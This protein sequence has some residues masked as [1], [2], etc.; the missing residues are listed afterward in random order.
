MTTSYEHTDDPSRSALA[1]PV[2]V[3][4]RTA[5]W[6]VALMSTPTTEAPSY[7][8]A[9]SAA[10]SE[11]SVSARTHE[12]PPCSSPNGWVL[13]CTGIVPAARSGAASVIAI[14][15]RAPRA[16]RAL[17][18]PVPEITSLSMPAPYRPSAAPPATVVTWPVARDGDRTLVFASAT[19]QDGNGE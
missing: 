11:P 2:T 17:S 3:P 5:L 10:A 9:C 1:T 6:C 7:R 15:I 13:P 18:R 12:A 4:D 14:P 19:L 16:P 8:A